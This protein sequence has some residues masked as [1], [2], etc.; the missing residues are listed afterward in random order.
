MAGL[1]LLSSITTWSKLNE[2]LG[3]ME[4]VLFILDFFFRLKDSFLANLGSE[5]CEVWII[6]RYVIDTYIFIYKIYQF[7]VESLRKFSIVFARLQQIGFRIFSICKNFFKY[8]FYVEKKFFRCFYFV[9]FFFL[10][11]RSLDEINFSTE[12]TFN[13][14]ANWSSLLIA[15]TVTEKFARKPN[16]LLRIL[17]RDWA[18]FDLLYTI[19]STLKLRYFD[20][21][22]VIRCTSKNSS[23][24][25]V[26]VFDPRWHPFTVRRI[27]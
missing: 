18:S 27:L 22:T 1:N 26:L 24:R 4:N 16:T 25:A 9:K 17:P 19:I 13:F 14:L 21:C 11:V 5:I 3:G 8:Y 12:Q 23:I 2:T 20:G 6:D 7:I 10:S 15:E